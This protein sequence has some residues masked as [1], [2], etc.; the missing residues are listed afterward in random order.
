MLINCNVWSRFIARLTIINKS[1]TYSRKQLKI[2][3][4]DLSLLVDLTSKQKS[5]KYLESMFW[6]CL[7]KERRPQTL[8][9]RYKI[10]YEQ[11]KGIHHFPCYD[12]SFGKRCRTCFL[13]C[14]TPMYI[15]YDSTLFQHDYSSYHLITNSKA[16]LY[17]REFNLTSR[18]V[19]VGK[20]ITH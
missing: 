20:V 18:T 2:I 15:E 6:H 1:V 10:I 16:L 4:H 11:W 8:C 5:K 13:F 9:H 3:K 12:M 7:W 14:I 19:E 17:Y